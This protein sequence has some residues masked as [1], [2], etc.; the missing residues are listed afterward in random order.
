MHQHCM[1]SESKTRKCWV[2]Q[3]GPV[4]YCD[5]LRPQEREQVEELA[6]HLMAV[7]TVCISCH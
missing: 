1:R 3:L 2:A 6:V 5:M 4:H 7:Q